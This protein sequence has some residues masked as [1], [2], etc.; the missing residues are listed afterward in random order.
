MTPLTGRVPLSRII[1]L[2]IS[3]RMKG[4]RALCALQNSTGKHSKDVILQDLKSAIALDP[5]Y[6]ESVALEDNHFDKLRQDEGFKSIV[7]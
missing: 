3:G 5:T 2:T 6:R 1:I 4:S 7:Q